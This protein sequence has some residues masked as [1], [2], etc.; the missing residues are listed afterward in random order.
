[1]C[2][3]QVVVQW[4]WQK[5]GFPEGKFWELVLSG[6]QGRVNLH[7]RWFSYTVNWCE[8]GGVSLCLFRTQHLKTA[9]GG[10]Q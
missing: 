9:L 2:C 4:A 8:A 7:S 6:R 5:V 10:E 1:M 3:T